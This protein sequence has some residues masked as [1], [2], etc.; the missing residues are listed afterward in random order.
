MQNKDNEQIARA[1]AK[2]RARQLLA[3]AVTV[4]LLILL[5]VVSSRPDLFG[6]FSKKTILTF[7]IV[8]ILAFV[9][10][11]SL[12][13]RCPACKNYLGNDIMQRNCRKCSA[14]LRDTD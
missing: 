5:A 10:F 11:S 13:W 6:I 12:N 4:A 8:I 3:I 7:M 2:M 1:F 9:N 14:R